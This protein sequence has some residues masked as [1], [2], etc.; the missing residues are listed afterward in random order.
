MEIKENA[1]GSITPSI[2]KDS[3]VIERYIKFCE[4]VN[5]DIYNTLSILDK[6]T[7]KLNQKALKE[8]IKYFETNSFV[9]KADKETSLKYLNVFIN[10]SKNDI[11]KYIGISSYEDIH[12]P[13]IN[14]NQIPGSTLEK[15]EAIFKTKNSIQLN[16]N[17][18]YIRLLAFYSQDEK[19]KACVKSCDEFGV[20]LYAKI[21]SIIFNKSVE[22]CLECRTTHNNHVLPYPEGKDRRM[23]AKQIVLYEIYGGYPDTRQHDEF[24]NYR[25]IF[26]EHFPKIKEWVGKMLK[27]NKSYIQDYFG[28]CKLLDRNFIKSDHIAIF[29]LFQLTEISIHKLF[30]KVL[31]LSR[32][33]YRGLKYYSNRYTIN[34]PLKD[35]FIIELSRDHKESAKAT[36]RTEFISLFDKLG[37][38]LD[39]E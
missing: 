19:F 28:N 6:H 8:A 35:L 4:E 22:E 33:E 14:L 2:S 21:A 13:K 26:E 20:D 12:I 29:S 31:N 5:K 1:L 37:L 3:K 16:Y 18:L 39:I 24:D 25:K 30:L 11:L 27:Y 9:G 17:K 15:L 10:L 38:V 34:V 23:Y 36:I 7:F 32:T